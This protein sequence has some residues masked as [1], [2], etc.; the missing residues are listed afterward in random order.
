MMVTKGVEQA[1]KAYNGN[2]GYKHVMY[3][4]VNNIV[5]CDCFQT[6]DDYIHYLNKTVELFKG[7]GLDITSSHDIT[8]AITNYNKATTDISEVGL[9]AYTDYR[10]Y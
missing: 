2:A 6:K 8:Q 10:Y 5:W 9:Q 1:T 4:P 7:A 3:D